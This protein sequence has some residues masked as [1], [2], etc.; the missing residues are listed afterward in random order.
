[1]P[2]G[3]S[4]NVTR[5]AA[6][7]VS[8]Q[9]PASAEA[10]PPMDA[11]NSRCRSMSCRRSCSSATRPRP[12]GAGCGGV[13]VPRRYRRFRSRNVGVA[14][15]C[16]CQAAAKAVAVSWSAL[17]PGRSEPSPAGRSA[18]VSTSSEVSGVRYSR[19]GGV[20]KK[21]AQTSPARS[22]R[23]KTGNSA[24]YTSTAHVRSASVTVSG[25]VCR[26][27]RECRKSPARGARPRRS[28]DR[29]KAAASVLPTRP[30]RRKGRP[31]LQHFPSPVPQ[32]RR[33]TDR[34]PRRAFSRVAR[35]VRR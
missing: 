19:C 2:S 32:V 35:P 14:P 28:Q 17:T 24:P 22:S 20:R 15:V 21:A 1:V 13:S 4:Q 23:P 12:S 16:R 8:A 34:L 31:H 26:S 30:S 6:M 10:D 3:A 27:G 25:T 9:E 11:T 5:P 7:R 33:P 29:A 18:R